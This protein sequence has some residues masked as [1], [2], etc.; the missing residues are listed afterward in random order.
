MSGVGIGSRIGSGS[1]GL[2]C[3][4]AVLWAATGCDTI[5]QDFNAFT[6][7]LIPLT[8]PEAAKIM[9]DPNDPDNRRRGT[10]L[11]ANSPFGGA[12]PY[13]NIYRDMAI[14]ERDPLAKAA[15]L[16]ALGRHG[17]PDDAIVI[18]ASLDDENPQ[19]KWAAAQAL[20]RIHNVAVV[21]DLLDVLR[22][23]EEQT[24]TRIAAAVAVGQYP[25]DRV[26]QGLVGALDDRELA[27]NLAAVTSLQTLTGEDFGLEA[28]A[29]LVWY[30]NAPEPF[31]GQREYLYPTYQRDTT[32]LERLAFWSSK[33]FE[34]PAPPAGLRPAGERRTY[35]D[36][37]EM[38]PDESG[39]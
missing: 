34:Q 8:P 7:E 31:A 22:R 23:D 5:G 25:Q 26:F 9:I 38:K 27:L 32:W 12:D 3:G 19:V 18:A 29:W 11:I 24:D 37:D 6:E 35:E 30:N 21:A 2:V 16:A 15:A 10:L 1:A 33:T 20:Q 28:R 17:V 36:D 14:R 39:G 13:V 4:A